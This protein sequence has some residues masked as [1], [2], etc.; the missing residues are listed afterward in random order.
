MIVTIDGPAS[1]GKGT[2]ARLLANHLDAFHLDSGLLYRA[3][4]YYIEEKNIDILD[5]DPDLYTD[6]LNHF[7]MEYNFC[8]QKS[9]IMEG[10]K[11]I[12]TLLRQQSIGKK[13]SQVAQIPLVRS[14]VTQKIRVLERRFASI[15]ADGRDMGSIV[16]PHAP[17][18]FYLDAP[19]SIRSQ[20]RYAET[21]QKQPAR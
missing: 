17:F 4:G 18:H 9:R 21:I 15:V 5:E 1:S 10:A 8:T 6:F 14:L 12:T 3:I 2:V 19:L 13:S 7:H 20:R 11:E 16:F